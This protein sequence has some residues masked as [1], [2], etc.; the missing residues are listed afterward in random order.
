MTQNI[1]RSCAPL[2]IGIAGGGTDVEPY[3]SVK[4]GRVFNTTINK[5][6]YCTIVPNDSHTMTI[7]STDYGTYETPLD[8]GPLKYDGNMDLVK[9]VT[10]HF[11]IIDGFDMS[12]HSEAPPGSG[13]GGSSTVIVSILKAVTTWIGEEMSNYD[14]AEL[15]Y[16]LEREDI[17]LKGGKQDQYAAAFGGFNM[18]EFTK[19]GTVVN[20][21]NLSE[22][23]VW[24]LEYRSLLCYTGKTRDSAGIIESQV[25]S[26]KAK[27]NEEA[28]DESKI[29]STKL[30]DALKK[31]DIEEAGL[32]LDET[33]KQKKKFSSKITNPMIDDLYST[34]IANGAYGGKVSGAGGG[35]FMYFICKND[36]KHIVAKEL[37]KKGAIVEDFVFEPRG[38]R[39]W[40]A[41]I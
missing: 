8:G 11:E 41:K 21:V 32:L 28:L 25:E 15:A 12:I 29:L 34:A 35:G 4:G 13:L 37:Q 17:G 9:A 38:A 10:N 24:E 3:A 40:R 2:R 20:P 27:S 5:Y 6:A 30:A 23:I 33:W 18:M 22:D 7:K 16:H 1:V 14:L 19:D 36:R 31:G 39:S 26:F